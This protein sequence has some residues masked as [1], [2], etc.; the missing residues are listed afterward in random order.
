[1]TEPRDQDKE[2]KPRFG[3]PDLLSTSV[4][5]IKKQHKTGIT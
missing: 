5:K 3:E 4:I 2:E 1:M